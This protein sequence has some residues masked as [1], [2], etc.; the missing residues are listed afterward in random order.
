MK[1]K[2]LR[3]PIMKHY[4]AFHLNSSSVTTKHFIGIIRKVFP[5]N[6]LLSLNNCRYSTVI[7]GKWTALWKLKPSN[8]T[9]G[10]IYLSRMPQIFSIS[11][12]FKNHSNTFLQ[13][14]CFISPVIIE[15]LEL[16]DEVGSQEK[17]HNVDN[18]L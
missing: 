5:C 3:K 2:I 17:W 8:P 1:L 14:H 16:N 10:T 6:I 4:T 12:L 9:I 15:C 18:Y 13:E 7:W 11:F